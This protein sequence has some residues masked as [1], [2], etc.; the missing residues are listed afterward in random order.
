MVPSL[1]EGVLLRE[2]RME[3][4]GVAP[5]LRYGRLMHGGKDGAGFARVWEENCA[6]SRRDRPFLTAGL[7][8]AGK[9]V[10]SRKA[11]RS[12]CMSV[13]ASL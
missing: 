7:C 2:L 10:R 12:Y 4:E 1:R 5:P 11:L 3:T 8:P 6:G 13:G 9:L